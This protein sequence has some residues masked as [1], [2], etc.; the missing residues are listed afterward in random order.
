M[1]YQV[2]DHHSIQQYGERLDSHIWDELTDKQQAGLLE[3]LFGK[4]R[5][6]I[7]AAVI[8]KLDVTVVIVS[9]YVAYEA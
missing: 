8:A 4:T 5:A 2:P 1:K 3:K 6:Q 7:G 9:A